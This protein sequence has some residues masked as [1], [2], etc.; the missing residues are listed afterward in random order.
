MAELWLQIICILVGFVLL[1]KGADWLVDGA[2]GIAKKLHVSALVV[3]LTVV[4]FGTSAPE[5]AVSVTSALKDAAGISVGNVSGSNIANI[6]LIL[7]VAALVRPLPVHKESFVLDLP[8]LLLA[9]GLFAILGVWG[10][11]LQWWDGI[12]LLAVFAVYMTILIV[13]AKRDAKDKPE[14]PLEEEAASR[15]AKLKQKTWMLCLLTVVGIAMVGIGGVLLVDGARYVA[16]HFGVDEG[17]VGL[18]VVAIG[19]SLPELVT[20]V[21]AAVKGET[22]IAVGNVVGSN[23]FNIFFVAGIASLFH[24]LA[25]SG[26]TNLIDALVALAAA[27]LLFECALVGRGKAG[28][29]S[30]FVMLACFVAYYCYLFAV[31][32]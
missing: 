21:V 20:S 32:L 27:L 23:I 2:S 16:L 3:G 17:V 22:D 6:L 29:A 7:G 19:T 25:F 14:P 26:G 12:A 28:R 5:L 24:P 11:A 8:V 13:K 4:A 10:G 18:T 1:I 30:G 9:S 15:F 31:R